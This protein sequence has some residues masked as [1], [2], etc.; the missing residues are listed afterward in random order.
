[1]RDLSEGTIL[2]HLEKLTED[3]ELDAEKDLAHVKPDAARFSVMQAAFLKTKTK[4]GQMNLTAAR[5]VTGDD[6]SFDE[7][8]LA[9]IFCS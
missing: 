2:S 9:R 5:R 7:L 6:Y 4:E 1:M 8:R 3:G